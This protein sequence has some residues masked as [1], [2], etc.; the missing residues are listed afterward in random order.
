MAEEKKRVMS[1]VF[2]NGSHCEVTS[3]IE[4][5]EGKNNGFNFALKC[6]SKNDDSNA[7]VKSIIMI[8]I[9]IKDV[10]DR[11]DVL[12]LGEKFKNKIISKYK[13]YDNIQLEEGIVKFIF[14]DVEFIHSIKSCVKYQKEVDKLIKTMVSIVKHIEKLI[15]NKNDR[16]K[17]TAQK[18]IENEEIK[19]EAA[20]SIPG[21]TVVE[22]G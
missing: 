3:A 6:I 14:K 17:K 5:I 7:D 19:K 1:T 9:D 15:S 10:F 2:K 11:A 16:M 20:E 22:E 4:V 18:K 12:N 8:E 21:A 13:K